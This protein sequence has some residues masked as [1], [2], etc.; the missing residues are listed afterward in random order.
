MWHFDLGIKEARL[1]FWF[2][3][4]FIFGILSIFL[5]LQFGRLYTDDKHVFTRFNQLNTGANHVYLTRRMIDELASKSMDGKKVLVLLMSDSILRGHGTSE[6]NSLS[7]KLVENKMLNDRGV[8]ILNLS[9]DGLTGLT[10]YMIHQYLRE[11]YPGAL[12]ITKLPTRIEALARSDMEHGYIWYDLKESLGESELPIIRSFDFPEWNELRT[13]GALNTYLGMLDYGQ[14]IRFKYAQA[15][16]TNMVRYKRL[17]FFDPILEIPN[18]EEDYFW[19]RENPNYTDGYISG[20]VDYWCKN[21][22]ARSLQ[23]NEFDQYIKEI[24]NEEWA[25]T[26]LLQ[27]GPVPFLREIFESDCYEQYQNNQAG[28]ATYFT[29]LGADVVNSNFVLTENS[30]YADMVHWSSEGVEKMAVAFSQAILQ[31]LNNTD[32]R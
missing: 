6:I 2:W 9:R 18:W 8:G 4:G 28:F 13:I 7:K 23:K 15:I 11:T 5:Y 31:K 16:Y 27:E 30:D 10:P 26:V 20:E 17:G 1:S 19:Y 22:G 3:N 12:L 29:S 24:I 25:N 32:A 21:F 14:S